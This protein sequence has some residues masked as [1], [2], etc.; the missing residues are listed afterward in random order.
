VTISSSGHVDKHTPNERASVIGLDKKRE[1][2]KKLSA[3]EAGSMFRA[4]AANRSDKKKKN[5]SSSS[6]SQLLGSQT[7]LSKSVSQ[8]NIS[9]LKD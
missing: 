2:E 9:S 4:Q 5:T 7:A 3:L 6:N 1:Q 8:R